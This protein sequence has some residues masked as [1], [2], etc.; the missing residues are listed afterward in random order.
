MKAFLF[1]CIC[2]LFCHLCLGFLGSRRESC[3]G[4]KHWER[5]YREPASG[6]AGLLD[7]YIRVLTL[8]VPRNPNM[9]ELHAV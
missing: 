3:L 4:V 9:Q 6:L 5:A 2:G 8:E 1:T 7:R